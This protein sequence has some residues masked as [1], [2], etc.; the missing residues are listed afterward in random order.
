MI[1]TLLLS[2][3][4]QAETPPAAPS[5]GLED[6]AYRVFL[7]QLQRH[8]RS[9]NR[10]EVVALVR[11]PLRVNSGPAN[12]RF[13]RYYRD[14]RSVRGDYAWIFSPRVRRAILAQRFAELFT[15]DQG[16]MIGGGEVW[17][18]RVCLDAR[19][20]RLGSIRVRAINR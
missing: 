17:F 12:A 6:S 7:T 2:L 19:C 18:D 13:S 4:L 11:F 16:V 8:I 10:R 1:A 5:W 9:G 3:T 20:A 15:R 14:A